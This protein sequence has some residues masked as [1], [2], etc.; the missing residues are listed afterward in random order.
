MNDIISMESKGL[1]IS[2]RIPNENEQLRDN[3]YKLVIK[4]MDGVRIEK[5]LLTREDHAKT[6]H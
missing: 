5:V 1:P 6:T 2:R 3:D 4:E